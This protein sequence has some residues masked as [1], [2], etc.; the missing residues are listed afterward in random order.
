M[1]DNNSDVR[2]M[3][4]AGL[5]PARLRNAQLICAACRAV[6]ATEQYNRQCER[7][8]KD[9]ALLQRRRGS[10]LSELAP[11]LRLTNEDSS[12]TWVQCVTSREG[13]VIWLPMSEGAL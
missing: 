12:I 5:A 7:V 6:N 8:I 4:I 13:D 11:T 9:T 2:V 10:A 3:H 1:H